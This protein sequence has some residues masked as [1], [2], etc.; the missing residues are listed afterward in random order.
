MRGVIEGYDSQSGR[1]TIRAKDGRVFQFDRRF[2]LKGSKEPRV[3][4][5]VAFRVRDGGVMKAVVVSHKRQWEWVAV[6]FEALLYLPL[7]L[8]K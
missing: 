8:M 5:N 4:A 1:G 2:L 3:E 6:V 7:A